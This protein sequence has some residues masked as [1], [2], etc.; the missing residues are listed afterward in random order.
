MSDGSG[1]AGGRALVDAIA[2]LHASDHALFADAITSF[3]DVDPSVSLG[4]LATVADTIVHDALDAG[5]APDATVDDITVVLAARAGLA[6]D[7]GDVERAH[8]DDAARRRGRDSLRSLVGAGALTSAAANRRLAAALTEI[9][10]LRTD[11]D[12]LEDRVAELGGARVLADELSAEL[13]RD[14]WIRARLRRAK[15][16]PPARAVIAL[17]RRLRVGR[18]AVS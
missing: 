5:F 15:S 7:L 13:E 2:A 14:E 1:D 12:A 3:G 17:R 6:V 11:R 9:D 4:G 18:S 10:A 8:R 16:T